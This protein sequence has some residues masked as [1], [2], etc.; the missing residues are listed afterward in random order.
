M[1]EGGVP[2]FFLAIRRVL[3]AVF[4][5]VV[6]FALKKM[7]HKMTLSCCCDCAKWKPYPASRLAVSELPDVRPSP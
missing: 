6:A 4:F 1:F 5:F 3:S 2:F 7:Q